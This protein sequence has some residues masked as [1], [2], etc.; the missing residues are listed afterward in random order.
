MTTN[1]AHQQPAG[2]T[3]AAPTSFTGDSHPHTRRSVE[4]EIRIDAPLSAVWNAL[5][6]AEELT[7]W[8][9]R[10]ARVEPGLGGK[11]V[12]RWDDTELDDTRIEVWE[13]ERH[14]RVVDVGGSWVGIACDYYLQA[15][16]GGGT[17]LR[18]V[19]S[20]FGAGEDWDEVLEA[21]GKGWDFELRGLRH[22]LERHQGTRRI[23]AAARVGYA[24]DHA[25]AWSSL[26]MPGGWFGPHGLSGLSSGSRFEVVTQTGDRLSG[27]VHT[28]QPPRQFVA[29]VD[30]WNDAFLRVHLYGSAATVWLSTY[31][32]AEEDVRAVE[33]RW[34]RSLAGIFDGLE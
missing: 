6:D 10:E 2:S 20:G 4:R 25:S 21:F 3:P 30:Q 15:Q 9:P 33:Q 29:A 24:S 1:A 7:R 12:M 14:L 11:I 34:A 19:S 31:G 22:Y 13:P 17:V 5:T 16:S 8:F 28:Q 32:V 23:I 27:L 26:M 18:V